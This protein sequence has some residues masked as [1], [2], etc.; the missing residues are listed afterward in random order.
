[1]IASLDG[2]LAAAD[3]EGAVIDVGGVGYALLC[4]ARTLGAMPPV[5]ERAELLVETH[6][7]DDRIQLYGFAGAAERAWFRLL[8]KVQGVGARTALGVLSAL[9]PA[10]LATAIAAEDRAALRG[11]PGI[12]PKAAGRIVSE[13]REH[14][15]TDAAPA[16]APRRSAAPDETASPAAAAVSALVNLGYGRAEAHGAVARAAAADDAA[17]GGGATLEGLI[18][19]GLRELAAP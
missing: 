13:L 11:V 4:S 3:A 16:P 1:M 9:A 12:G 15:E 8:V 6:L 10:E 19:R 7:R 2:R 18:R 14:A 5:G 17:G